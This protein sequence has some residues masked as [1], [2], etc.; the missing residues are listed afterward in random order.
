MRHALKF[1]RMETI[2][3]FGPSSV[4]SSLEFFGNYNVSLKDRK[5]I[6]VGS[7]TRKAMEE[8]GIKADGVVNAADVDRLINIIKT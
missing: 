6:A 8:S 3:F 5:L 2:V 1:K 4:R 7:G